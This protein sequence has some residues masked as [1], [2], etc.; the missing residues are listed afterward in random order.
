MAKKP[1]RRAQR[2][3]GNSLKGAGIRVDGIE[4]VMENLATEIDLIRGA[5]IGGLY[6][7]GLKVLAEAKKTHNAPRDT[8][9]L[10][11]SGYVRR[12]PE[13]DRAVEIG[14]TANYALHV[15]ENLE[16]HHAA[17]RAKFLEIPLEE[18]QDEIIDIVAKT[19]KKRK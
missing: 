1:S 11:N 10:V 17:G 7:A 4:E 3:A 14:F 5:S 6:A 15:H 18:M 12:T 16:S 9:N 19:A 8:G 13:N 2:K